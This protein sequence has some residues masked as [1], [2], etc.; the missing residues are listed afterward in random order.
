MFTNFRIYLII[1]ALVSTA[2]LSSFLT[3]NYKDGR[4]A[5]KEQKAREEYILELKKRQEEYNAKVQELNKRALDQQAKLANL[6]TELEKKYADANKRASQALAKYNDLVANGW[7]LRDPGATTKSALQDPGTSKGG[8]ASTSSSS[9]G[10]TCSGELSREAS[11]FLLQFASD[12]DKVV[13]QLRVTQE[14]A[15]RLRNICQ[16][17][18]VE[19]TEKNTNNK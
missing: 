13:E 11:E 6:N 5:L 15:K 2:I 8:I 12:A 7:R 4:Y 1:G 18:L 17:A 10:A 14:Y 3:A 9:N 16:E 19:N